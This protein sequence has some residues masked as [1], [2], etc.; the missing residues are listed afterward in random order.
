MKKQGKIIKLKKMLIK[1]INN[2]YFKKKFKKWRHLN[3]FKNN[4]KVNFQ[5]AILIFLH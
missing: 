4:I 3:N 5:E 2:N 1:L